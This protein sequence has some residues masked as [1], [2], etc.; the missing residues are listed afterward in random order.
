MFNSW[1]QRSTLIISFIFQNSYLKG[2]ILKNGSFSQNNFQ[3]PSGSSRCISI[4][5]TTRLCCLF[6]KFFQLHS[7]QNHIP[8]HIRHI[9]HEN[10]A[11]YVNRSFFIHSLKFQKTYLT[12]AFQIVFLILLY[13]PLFLC[14]SCIFHIRTV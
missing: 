12:L 8:L 14:I 3:F 7:R 10:A 11:H 4:H 6:G 13:L 9:L 2:S 1:F 5:S